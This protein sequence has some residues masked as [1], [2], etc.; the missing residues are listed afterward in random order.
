MC[1]VVSTIFFNSIYAAWWTVFWKL[2]LILSESYL[3]YECIHCSL[4]E[5]DVPYS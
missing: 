2:T 3:F 4:K 1:R 5:T